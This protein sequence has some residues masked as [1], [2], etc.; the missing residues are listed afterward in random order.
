MDQITTAE[1]SDE[2]YDFTMY[3]DRSHDIAEIIQDMWNISKMDFKT[4]EMLINLVYLALSHVFEVLN[5]GERKD[6]RNMLLKI[7]EQRDKVK[8]YLKKSLSIFSH[9]SFQELPIHLNSMWASHV[10]RITFMNRLIKK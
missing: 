3:S 5:T 4:M 7:F 9:A 6:L 8:R 10:S 2:T 1:L